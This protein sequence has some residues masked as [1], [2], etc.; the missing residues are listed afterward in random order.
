[1]VSS[2]FLVVIFGLLIL[3]VPST[4]LAQTRP[5]AM[6]R[7]V[8]C[9]AAPGAARISAGRHGPRRPA[10]SL[11]TAPSSSRPIQAKMGQKIL[12]YAVVLWGRGRNRRVYSLAPKGSMLDGRRLRHIEPLSRLEQRLGPITFSW[13]Q[14]E[15]YQQHHALPPP[16]RGNP[17]YSNAVLF[18]PRHGR[19]IG[20]DRIEYHETRLVHSRAIRLR[21]P[22]SPRPL[23]PPQ[24]LG[25]PHE[26]PTRRR[27]IRLPWA[28]RLARGMTS[29]RSPSGWALGSRPSILEITRA[30]PTAPRL[31]VWNGLGTMRYKVAV[32]WAGGRIASDGKDAN[33]R[34]GIRPTV[35][36][37]S[38]RRADGLVGFLTSYFNVPNVFG[39]ST[40]R[41]GHQ[42]DRYQGA[43]CADVIIGAARRAGAKL[44]YT[45][46]AGLRHLARPVTP[47][48]LV[49]KTGIQ[50]LAPVRRGIS[51]NRSAAAGRADS[52]QPGRA[53]RFQ[54]GRRAAPSA[55]RLLSIPFDRNLA[56]RRT[57]HRART[58]LARSTHA[59]R[60]VR[61]GDLVLIDYVNFNETH[62]TWDHVAVLSQDRGRPGVLDPSDLILHVGYLAGLTEAPI[63]D[64]AP[65]RIQVLRFHRSILRAMHMVP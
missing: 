55:R 60:P 37:V 18:G 6:V 63:R 8:G 7:I 49:T 61:P 56:F 33:D 52:S 51:S 43:D 59:L 40:G 3:E 16:N 32:E 36:R 4:G 58:H 54:P 29:R 14:V 45:S 25:Q 38:F 65:A 20:L 27:G 10:A 22:G 42:T 39:S 53:P 31:R 23:R 48:I 28:S 19:W 46:A 15:P 26:P 12:L 11:C 21:S 2:E 9:I 24:Q 50:A 5:D 35:F 44:C 34:G 64:E 1:M 17:A 30:T 13:S 62:R 57:S 47:I 41:W